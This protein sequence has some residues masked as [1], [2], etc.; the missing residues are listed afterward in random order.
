MKILLDASFVYN[1]VTGL[2]QYAFHL[3]RNLGKIDKENKYVVIL[4]TQL[5]P[6]NELIRV[7]ETFN[8]FEFLRFNI[9]PIGPRRDIKFLFIK[10]KLEPYDVFHSLSS[11]FPLAM[12]KN[13]VVTIHDLT[14]LRYPKYLGK[15]SYLK[16]AYMNFIYNKAAKNASRIITVSDNTRKDFMK[17]FPVPQTKIQR[18][19]NGFEKLRFRSIDLQKKFGIN[20]KYFLYVGDSRPHKNLIGLIKAF[21][22][23]QNVNEDFILILAGNIT[24]DTKDYQSTRTIGRV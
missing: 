2:S 3:I 20:K 17:H 10:K 4:N 23:I 18:I 12:K 14:Y 11:N 13:S 21:D 19:Y 24:I 8:N 22:L 6:E 5:S 7:I 1:Q 16:I 9:K 15:L